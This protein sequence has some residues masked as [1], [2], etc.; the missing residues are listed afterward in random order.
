MGGG[1][2]P[3]CADRARVMM[4]DEAIALMKSGTWLGTSTTPALHLPL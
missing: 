1:V 2:A 3:G 4:D